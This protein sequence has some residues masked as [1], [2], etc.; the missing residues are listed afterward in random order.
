MTTYSKAGFKLAYTKFLNK[1]VLSKYSIFAG[2]K[3]RVKT[4]LQT[5]KTVSE[6]I[7]DGPILILSR[8]VQSRPNV[9]QHDAVR[10]LT[11]LGSG[12]REA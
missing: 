6:T 12:V 7:R 11:S 10:H 2:E 4:G 9:S 1:Q 3:T 5:R 8:R